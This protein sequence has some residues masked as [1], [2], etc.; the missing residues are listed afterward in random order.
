MTFFL[1]VPH[2]FFIFCCQKLEQNVLARKHHKNTNFNQN[3][4]EDRKTGCQELPDRIAWFRCSINATS[5]KTLTST[6]CFFRTER[7]ANMDRAESDQS[8]MM[9]DGLPWCSGPHCD[10]FS[11]TN[12][13]PWS[14]TL[15]YESQ[16]SNRQCCIAKL[17]PKGPFNTSVTLSHNFRSLLFFFRIHLQG[18]LHIRGIVFFSGSPAFFFTVQSLGIKS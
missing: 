17:Q 4:W 5:A 6:Q 14:G 18:F 1:M 11:I 7:V 16:L 9:Y 2:L 15:L 12:I 10:T 3:F 8:L 13:P